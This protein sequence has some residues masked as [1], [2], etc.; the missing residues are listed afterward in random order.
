MR[1]GVRKCFCVDKADTQRKKKTKLDYYR[2]CASFSYC[3]FMFG[4]DE[5]MPIAIWGFCYLTIR[6]FVRWFV[7]VVWRSVVVFV[8]M[9]MGDVALMRYLNLYLQ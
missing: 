8:Y 5:R 4:F 7:A 1:K 6:T 9:T 3:R 2:Y